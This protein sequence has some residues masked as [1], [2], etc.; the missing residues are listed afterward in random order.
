MYEH[1]AQGIFFNQYVSDGVGKLVAL[2][3]RHVFVDQNVHVQESYV[4][5]DARPDSV[6]HQNAGNGERGLFDRLEFVVRQAPVYESV[7]RA[8]HD[9]ES[10]VEDHEGDQYAAYVVKEIPLRENSGEKQD[11]KDGKR[12]Q[13]V[14]PV[15][16]GVGNQGLT[17]ELH[18]QA[19]SF[20]IQDLFYDHGQPCYRDHR[21]GEDKIPTAES[22]QGVDKDPEGYGEEQS[23]DEESDE[24]LEF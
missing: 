6:D 12:T 1:V 19:V 7:E 18:A 17:L 15:V 21:P 4:P 5:V 20:L 23:A 11:Y 2:E 14:R 8:S 13:G 3:D 24:R 16:P 9:L 22:H 10:G